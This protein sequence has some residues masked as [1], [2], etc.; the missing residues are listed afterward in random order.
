MHITTQLDEEV[1]GTVEYDEAKNPISL[2]YNK[3]KAYLLYSRYM[4]YDSQ[5]RLIQYKVMYDSST[6]VEDHR[7]GYSGDRIISDTGIFRLTGYIVVLSTFEYDEK[8]RIVVV[9]RKII[10]FEGSPDS[11]EQLEPVIYQYDSN[12]NL[13][14]HNFSY[15]NK[16]NFRRTNKVWMFI[17]RDYSRNNLE[18]ATHYN[19]HGLPIRFSNSK[20]PLFYTGSLISIDYDCK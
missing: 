16:I 17:Q 10:D 9:N 6:E 13:V 15:D 4:F 3:E 5:N 1:I 12:D 2:T 18:G 19:E 11:W 14:D 7:Y 8:G 20:D